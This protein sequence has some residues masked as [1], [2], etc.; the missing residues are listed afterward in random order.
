V[1]LRVQNT[2][3]GEGAVRA[4]F[5]SL[6]AFVLLNHAAMA[7]NVSITG[8]QVTWYGVF[9]PKQVKLVDAPESLAGK[10]EVI[11]GITPP[12]TNSDTI[13]VAVDT[14]F[15]YGFVLNSSPSGA[16]V[17]LKF[18]Y[19]I[20]PPGMLDVVTK[21]PK[22]RDEVNVPIF[23]GQND[24]FIGKPIQGDNFPVGKWTMQVW[25]GDKMLLTKD[26]TV[27]K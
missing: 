24:L 8:G 26:F 10:R 21:Q 11:T 20:P 15:G 6:I 22:T 1:D 3:L 23:L 19:L 18:V 16:P 7:Q 5:A 13:P 25:Y 17:T 2:Q 12:S 4:L 14:T 9:T 27:T